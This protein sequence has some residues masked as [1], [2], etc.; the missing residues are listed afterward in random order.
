MKSSLEVQNIMGKINHGANRS[1]SHKTEC[2]AKRSM[3]G[4]QKQLTWSP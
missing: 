2:D 3:L 4:A 1:L